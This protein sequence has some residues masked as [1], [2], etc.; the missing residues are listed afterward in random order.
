LEHRKVALDTAVLYSYLIGDSD[1]ERGRWARG[2]VKKLRDRECYEVII[3]QAVL[4]ELVAI[5]D[6][7]YENLREEFVNRF[8]ARVH[9][10]INNLGAKCLPFDVKV[11]Y[12]IDPELICKEE[13]WVDPADLLITCHAA[14]EGCEILITDDTRM[15]KSRKLQDVTKTIRE[16]I[17]R[18]GGLIITDELS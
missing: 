3:S 7:E 6:K 2:V 15:I 16:K 10:F 1:R 9:N 11:L 5:L 14:A 8:L 13:E 17:G 12:N 4:G 18:L